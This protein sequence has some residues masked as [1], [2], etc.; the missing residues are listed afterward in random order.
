[1][2]L[3]LVTFVWGLVGWSFWAWSMSM[4]DQELREHHQFVLL[5]SDMKKECTE[6][7]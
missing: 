2:S 5:V 4:R 7:D 3:D 1:M 6:D